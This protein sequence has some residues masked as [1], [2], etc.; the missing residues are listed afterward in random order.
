MKFRPKSLYYGWVVAAAAGGMEFANAASAI[1]ILT[2]FV[3]PMTEEFG[4]TRTEIAGATS[5]GAILGAALAPFIGRLVDRVGS[6]M[7]LVVSGS[8][9]GL[10]CI[11]LSLMQTLLGFYLAFT[12][13]RVADQGGVKIGAS[14][15]AG[16]WFLRYRGRVTGLVFFA[17]TAGLIVL[18]PLTQLV[19]SQWGWRD[20]WLMLGGGM[21]LLG[22]V[23]CALLVRRQ[24]EDLGL[25]IDGSRAENGEE[26]SWQTR[27]PEEERSLTLGEVSRT[28]TFW[29]V[30]V[31]L[32]M[33]S[34]ATAGASL[35]LV[36]HLTEQGINPAAAVGAISVMATSGAAGALLVGAAADRVSVRWM[37]AFLYGIGAGSLGL[38][39]VT[40]TLVE[41]YLFAVL[42][43]LAGAGINTLA[44]IM[45]ASYYGRG[46]LGAIY[47]VSRAAQ[48]TGFALG[49]LV[50]GMVYDAT[51]NYRGAFF[52]LAW[53][54]LAAALLVVVAGRGATANQGVSPPS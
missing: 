50:S 34:N 9:I 4:W 29:G 43:G 44:P 41:A 3:V 17:G 51:G 49:P 52:T 8:V 36:P 14:V 7:V 35:H 33:V 22:V 37:M 39:I 16:K 21:F 47:G 46:A 1:S 42:Q 2:I 31:S 15:T 53:L 25:V 11:Y 12:A 10:A 20:A 40:D 18:A 13:S 24:P 5:V 45:W 27:V 28:P 32:F 38:L 23:P 6:R 54:A 19:I 26:Q 30:L 48:V